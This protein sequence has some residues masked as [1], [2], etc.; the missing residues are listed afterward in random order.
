MRRTS[1]A[2]LLIC[3]I[4]LW[5]GYVFA[6]D[7]IRVA[8]YGEAMHIILVDLTPPMRVACDQFGW[9]LARTMPTAHQ[10]IQ[11]HWAEVSSGDI[12]DVR[13]ILGETVEPTTTDIR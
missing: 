8:G 1:N 2:P 5:A 6:G 3:L 10:W 12:I 7:L 9:G 4:A 11:E 13:F